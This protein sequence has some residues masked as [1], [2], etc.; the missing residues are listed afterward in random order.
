VVENTPE[1]KALVLRKKLAVSIKRKAS[2]S[3][4]KGKENRRYAEIA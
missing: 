3:G 4:G 2:L 1:K